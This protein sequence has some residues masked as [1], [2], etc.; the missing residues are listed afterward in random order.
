M[1]KP[2]DKSTTWILLRDAH[3]H[4]VETYQSPSLAKRLLISSL[5]AGKVRCRSLCTQGRAGKTDPAVNDPAFWNELPPGRTSGQVVMY[6]NW[7]ESTAYR[8]GEHGRYFAYRIELAEADLRT[9]L[10]WLKTSNDSITEPKGPQVSRVRQLLREL[11]YDP[12]H[13]PADLGTNKINKIVNDKFR[14]RDEKSVD[15]D[16]IARAIGRRTDRRR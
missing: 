13:M 9:L 4:L 10:P 1:A 8:W 6:P 7:L 2:N 14:E 3:A 5:A 11:G 16:S 15:R 12:D